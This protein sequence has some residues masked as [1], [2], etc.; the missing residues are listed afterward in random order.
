[1]PIN[2]VSA[3]WVSCRCRLPHEY[4]DNIGWFDWPQE[5]G[6]LYSMR[7]CFPCSLLLLFFLFCKIYRWAE[8]TNYVHRSCF[9]IDLLVFCSVFVFRLYEMYRF[10]NFNAKLL[11]T[12]IRFCVKCRCVSLQAMNVVWVFFFVFAIRI[13]LNIDTK[14]EYMYYTTVPISINPKWVDGKFLYNTLYIP[15]TVI[16]L[17]RKKMYMN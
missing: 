10:A 16:V 1:M 6:S 13:Y 3:D 5:H 8:H 17:L 9:T 7:Y 11:E 15:H 4:F 12:R 2:I 14:A